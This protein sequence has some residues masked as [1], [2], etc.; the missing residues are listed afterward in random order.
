[1]WHSTSNTFIDIII[2]ICYNINNFRSYPNVRTYIGEPMRDKNPLHPSAL[3]IRDI[4]PG[5]HIIGYSTRFGI[6]G[7][8]LILGRP[9]VENYGDEEYAGP[10]VVELMSV[11]DGEIFT[12]F[13]ES[14][15][16]ITSP[17]G[18][19]HDHAYVVDNRK[20]HLLPQ[21]PPRRITSLSH[22]EK[23]PSSTF[24]IEVGW[25]QPTHR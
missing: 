11:T 19:W 14:M 4:T 3:R 7:E 10:C 25:D 23:R 24:T 15:G 22:L 20:R 5:R 12:D 18:K 1:M 21:E 8:Y 13:L 16:V 6:E 17:S 9:F 2:I